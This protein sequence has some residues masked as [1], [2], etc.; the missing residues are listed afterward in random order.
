M[1]WPCERTHRFKALQKK[2][3]A[4]QF[5]CWTYI[6]QHPPA[7]TPAGPPGPVHRPPRS[8]RSPNSARTL[9]RELDGRRHE[10]RGARPGPGRWGGRRPPRRCWDR[11]CHQ[12]LGFIQPVGS[13]SGRF[14]GGKTGRNSSTG[15]CLTKQSLYCSFMID[16]L[17]LMSSSGRE[18]SE[19]DMCI[20]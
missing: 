15:T 18:G 6:F 12:R 2:K 14:S 17:E 13:K 7:S 16:D 1:H 19:K 3:L 4:G 8:A 5:H 20:L 10:G 9:S 11:S